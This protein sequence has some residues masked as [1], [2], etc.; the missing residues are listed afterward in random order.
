MSNLV[1][2]ISHIGVKIFQSLQ[3]YLVLATVN[4]GGFCKMPLNEIITD[5]TA[6][7]TTVI[8]RINNGFI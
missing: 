7:Q 3:N 4:S 5:R 6:A 1:V 2:A 8:L